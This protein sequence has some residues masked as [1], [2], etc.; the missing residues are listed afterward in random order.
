MGVGAEGVV[1][2]TI[3]MRV[4]QRDCPETVGRRD[5]IVEAT[6]IG[7]A[8]ARLS[9]AEQRHNGS[10]LAIMSLDPRQRQAARVQI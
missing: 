10:A 5:H 7:A 9:R 4:R 6:L 1:I 3:E 8:V 2:A